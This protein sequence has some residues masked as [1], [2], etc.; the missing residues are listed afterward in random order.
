MFVNLT[1]HAVTL[2]GTDGTRRTVA[3]SG[4]ARIDST[5][6][7]FVITEGDE[8]FPD[9]I[10]IYGQTLYGAPVGL[11]E[12]KD[13]V[14]YIVSALFSG[15]VGDR[16]DVVYPGTGPKD[17]CIRDDKGQIVAVTRLIRA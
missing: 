9:G 13:G 16:I 11:P 1:P 6:G 3:S 12:P 2:Q 17:G 14:T 8:L 15:R 7:D 10:A 4:I 5:P